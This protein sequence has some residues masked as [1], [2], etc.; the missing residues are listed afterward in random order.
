MPLSYLQNLEIKQAEQIE[1]V[2]TASELFWEIA[3]E[4]EDKS[5]NNHFA[6]GGG[7][8]SVGDIKDRLAEM[9]KGRGLD[10]EHDSV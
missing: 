9:K 3:F 10:F 7:K 2:V 5:G 6:K 4:S 1:M 8:R